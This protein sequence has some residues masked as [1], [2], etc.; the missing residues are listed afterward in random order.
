MRVITYRMCSYETFDPVV[1]SQLSLLVLFSLHARAHGLTGCRYEAAYDVRRTDCMFCHVTYRLLSVYLQKTFSSVKQ[2][3]SEIF[4]L[5][6][7]NNN[8]KNKKR[9]MFM[10]FIPNIIMNQLFAIIYYII[11]Q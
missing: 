3:L 6:L 7:K 5:F 8:G 9:Q 4:Y 2:G 11:Q 1:I 10:L